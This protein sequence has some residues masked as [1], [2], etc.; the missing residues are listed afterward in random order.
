[1][2]KYSRTEAEKLKCI[3][4]LKDRGVSVNSDSFMYEED[5]QGRIMACAGIMYVGIIE[6]FACDNPMAGFRVA[7]QV[8]GHMRRDVRYCVAMIPEGKN[9]NLEKDYLKDGFSVWD[10]N[11]NLYIKEL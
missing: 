7:Q 8:Q 3:Q 6:P 1:M 11:I 9:E 4:Y 10:K 5:G 2:I